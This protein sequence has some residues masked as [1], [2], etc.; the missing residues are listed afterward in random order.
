MDPRANN[1]TPAG[2]YIQDITE[3]WVFVF[4][5]EE[6]KKTKQE[7]HEVSHSSTFFP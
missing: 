2:F 6:T 4:L 5:S 7:A 3:Q 1:V